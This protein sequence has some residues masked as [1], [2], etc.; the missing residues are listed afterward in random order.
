MGGNLPDYSEM[1]RTGVEN[2][3]KNTIKSLSGDFAK[4]NLGG[5][6]KGKIEKGACGGRG[7]ILRGSIRPGESRSG[8]KDIGCKRV[9]RLQLYVRRKNQKGL[10]TEV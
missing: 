8:C 9:K 6:K 3:R 10:A 1:E 2:Q 5:M 7:G 4:K